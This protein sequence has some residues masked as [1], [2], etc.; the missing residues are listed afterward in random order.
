[1]NINNSRLVHPSGAWQES[2]LTAL[3]ESHTEGSYLERSIS[4]IAGDFNS[5][6]SKLR[7][8]EDPVQ[9]APDFVPQTT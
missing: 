6:V 4:E 8:M 5:F 3:A 2:F 9:V 7:A 1:M